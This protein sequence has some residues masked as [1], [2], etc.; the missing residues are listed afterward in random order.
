MKMRRPDDDVALADGLGFVV[1]DGPY[2]VHLSESIEIK[3]VGITP[4]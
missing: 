1:E 4:L 3:Q 2:K